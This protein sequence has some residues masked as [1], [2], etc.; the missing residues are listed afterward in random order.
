MWKPPEPPRAQSKGR[1]N[2]AKPGKC[3][4]ERPR[5]CSPQNSVIPSA[6]EGPCVSQDAAQS[7]PGQQPD[8]PSFRILCGKVRNKN[9]DKRTTFTSETRSGQVLPEIEA[10][11]FEQPNGGAAAVVSRLKFQIGTTCQFPNQTKI[12]HPERS[13]RIR[14]ANPTAESR[15]LLFSRP[16]INVGA[17]VPLVQLSGRTRLQSCR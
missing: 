1:S 15:D 11:I 4:P 5:S 14:K 12:C 7:H 10:P 16:Q 9:L 2:R 6:V 17:S 13:P 8:T 3:R